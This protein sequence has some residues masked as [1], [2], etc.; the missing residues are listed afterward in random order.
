MSGKGKLS[1]KGDKTEKKKKKRKAVHEEEE[2]LPDEGDFQQHPR[3]L[4]N[5]IRKLTVL[6]SSTG[7]LPVET[8]DDFR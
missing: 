5:G 3:F 1:F 7:W 2:K 6:D 8:L 4:H